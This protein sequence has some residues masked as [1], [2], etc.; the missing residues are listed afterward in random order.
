MIHTTRS[1]IAAC[2]LFLLCV[3]VARAA[4]KQPNIVVFLVDDLG[5][6]DTSL[7]F[8][9]DEEGRP[10]R[11]PLNDYYRT[12]NME[13]M[14]EL[15]IRFNNFYAMSVCSPA[16]A[17]LLTGQ[18]PARHRTTNWIK[19]DANNAGPQGPPEWNWQGLRSGD[20][21]LQSLLGEQG[22]RTI[23]IGKGHFGPRRSEGADP[24][25][26]GFDVNIAGTPYGMP[27]SYRGEDRY[28]VYSGGWPAPVPHLEKY[29]DTDTWL[30]EALT[31]EAKE[32]VAKAV[33]EGVPFFL[34]FSHYAVH[35][36][37]EIDPRFAAHYADSG[38]DEQAQG[39]ATLVEG[40]DKSL[41]DLLDH[42]DK[43]GI[44]EN[45]L[46]FFLGDNGSDAPL[47]NPHQVAAAE[48]LRG[49]KGSHYEGGVRTAFMA[50]W[51]KRNASNPYQQRLPIAAGAI[52]SQVA[53]IQ[54]IF[55]TLLKLV[56][57]TWPEEHMVDGYALDLL[58]T[59]QSDPDRPEQF[60]MHYPHAP[61]RSDYWTSWR[62]GD[63]K[64]IYHYV[65]SK[66][67]NQ[68]Y[69]LYN[70]KADPAEQRDLAREEPEEL[71]RM[72]E[73]LIA[74]LEDHDALYPVSETGDEE[75]RPHRP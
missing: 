60:L 69:Q 10:K 38:Q 12:P 68:H 70:L 25:N 75:L 2:L 27:G 72:M 58:L 20:T 18:N 49:M 26:L 33:S 43:L 21:M 36:P 4:V 34:H 11:Y 31:L 41:G 48:P 13:R 52:Q 6:M 73:G 23:H 45:T 17:S 44:A 55:P 24:L 19:F 54:D 29:H 56:G 16:R 37:F 8:L 67:I 65:P 64:V 1:K 50:A 71:R 63:W 62:D 51:A 46:I 32:Q 57:A 39:F 3:P 15:G 22:Y 14:A 9:T 74:A 28:G 42:I 61:H 53:S 35:S 40:M 59:G 5:M 47:G 30:T 7:P 66:W